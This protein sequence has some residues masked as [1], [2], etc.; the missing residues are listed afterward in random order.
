MIARVMWT[1]PTCEGE[2]GGG[3]EW[4][5]GGARGGAGVLRWGGGD[6]GRDG[7]GD[8]GGGLTLHHNHRNGSGRRYAQNCH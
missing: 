3:S 5:E 1:S 7:G 4:G 8:G 2:E 6:A